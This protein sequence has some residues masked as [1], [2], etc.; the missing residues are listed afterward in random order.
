MP[1]PKSGT[2]QQP[3]LEALYI[4]YKKVFFQ[5]RL[6]AL[7]IDVVYLQ[8]RSKITDNVRFYLWV[9]FITGLFCGY[10][11]AACA[12]GRFLLDH[13]HLW[14]WTIPSDAPSI[15]R[16]A[17][18]IAAFLATFL[19]TPTMVVV[20]LFL[21]WADHRL[22]DRDVN[23][24]FQD[25]SY[26]LVGAYVFANWAMMIVTGAMFRPRFHHI[27]VASILG[28]Y[29]FGNLLLLPA[30]GIFM[31]ISFVSYDLWKEWKRPR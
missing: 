8:T 26:S 22:E 14:K 10:N 29:G 6:C 17:E 24:Q 5:P 18:L 31:I 7:E 13:F 19:A 1:T 28:V 9:L 2:I 3:D 30:C 21:I 23:Y 4:P 27:S 25:H 12:L 16:H 11:I 20:F 15:E